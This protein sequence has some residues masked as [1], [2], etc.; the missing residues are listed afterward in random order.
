MSQH[1]YDPCWVERE[2]S[3]IPPNQ[4]PLTDLGGHHKVLKRFSSVESSH[5]AN[6]L[7][8]L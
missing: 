4:S 2:L 8:F 1:L 6:I 5:Q 3:V 7:T